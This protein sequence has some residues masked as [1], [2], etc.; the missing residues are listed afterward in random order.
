MQEIVGRVVKPG[1][2]PKGANKGWILRLQERC[3]QIERGVSYSL[4]EEKKIECVCIEEG[5]SPSQ[6]SLEGKNC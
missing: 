3:L 4:G 2:E 6:D 1:F 5:S